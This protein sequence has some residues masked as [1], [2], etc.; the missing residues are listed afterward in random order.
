MDLSLNYC[1]ECAK[2]LDQCRCEGGPAIDG[3]GLTPDEIWGVD[4][5]RR[6][7]TDARGPR[8]VSGPQE[9]KLTKPEMRRLAELLGP[10]PGPSAGLDQAPSL[11]ATTSSRDGSHLKRV[12]AVMAC[13]NCSARMEERGCKRRCP[14]CGYFEDC[15]NL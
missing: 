3:P 9:A 15:A 1:A 14:T 8:R 2:S 10:S 7:R 5:R 13:L 11:Y 12:E 4:E 6:V